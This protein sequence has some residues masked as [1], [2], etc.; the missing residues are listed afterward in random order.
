MPINWGDFWKGL[1]SAVGSETAETAPAPTQQ[2]AATSQQV[3]PPPP[4]GVMPVPV[5][6]PGLA[7]H[8]PPMA[9]AVTTAVTP[10]APVNQTPAQ[11]AQAAEQPAAPATPPP[12]PI[13]IED[14]QNLIRQSAAIQAQSAVAVVPQT[15]QATPAHASDFIL[16]MS[17]AEFNDQWEKDPTP[18]INAI[19]ADSG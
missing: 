17:H 15:A 12:P 7:V 5:V 10:A 18:I 4:G 16:T 9:T 19:M 11:V 2:P 14:V 13:T 3:N 1:M 6:D 8:T